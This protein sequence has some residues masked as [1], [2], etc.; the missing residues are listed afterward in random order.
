MFMRCHVPPERWSNDAM[1]LGDEE[2][3]HLSHVLRG[4]VGMPVEV[5]DGQGRVA[6][7]RVR[8][9]DR[10]RVEVAVE[11]V[12]QVPAPRVRVTLVQALPREQKLDLVLQKATELG[13][14]EIV[15][16]LA[17]NC[18]A[19]P[20]RDDADAKQSRWSKIVLNAAR[21]CGTAWMP[22]VRAPV[23]LLD[24]VKALPSAGLLL[25]CSLEPDAVALREPMARARGV[26]T[27]AAAAVGPEGDFSA[28]ERKALRDAGGIP[29]SLGDLTLRA[30][31]A[32]LYVLSVLKY[33]LLDH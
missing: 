16:V 8:V 25:S 30:E 27:S 20:R 1:A 29:V 11:Q 3:H 15:P 31:T 7:T 22:V 13:V 33:E 6:H 10:H 28:R 12:I 32:A 2:L 14:A 17:D 5:F 24:A 19:R 9:L 21:Q 23:P 4:E 26:V 18:V